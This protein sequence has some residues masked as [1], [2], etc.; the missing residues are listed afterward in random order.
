MLLHYGI[1]RWYPQYAE[2][3]GLIPLMLFVG[4]LR[5]SDFWSSHLLIAGYERRLLALNGATVVC[6]SLVWLAWTTPWK[7][8]PTSLWD[9]GLLAALLSL[10]GYLATAGAAWRVRRA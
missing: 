7:H 10:F 6:A 3:V 9:I 8:A 2:A 5:V 1:A 4:V